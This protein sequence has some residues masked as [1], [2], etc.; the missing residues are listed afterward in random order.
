MDA[1]TKLNILGLA[2]SAVLL[3]MACIKADRVRAWRTRFHPS[4]EELPDGAF[5]VGRVTLVAA[6]C[7]GVFLAV[8]GFAVS[9]DAEWSDDE[10]TSAV[11]G[12][13]AALDG[14]IELGDIYDTGFDDDGYATTIES[15]IVEHGG[16]D[17]P[18]FGAYASPSGTNKGDEATYQVT[19][20]GASATFCMHVTRMRSK[21]NDWNAPGIAGGEGT[22]VV[23]GYRYAVTSRKGEC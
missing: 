13:T 11:E 6:A 8:Q 1:L 16:G 2:L 14:S 19:A 21:E 9:D 23:P 17:A 18:Q 5:V 22:A 3:A 4:G 10:L 7:A 15:E 20:S 12:A